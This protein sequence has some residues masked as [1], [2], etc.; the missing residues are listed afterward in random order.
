MSDHGCWAGG[1][2]KVFGVVAGCGVS[3]R[4]WVLK[5]RSSATGT[6]P[7]WVVVVV[8][9]V[10]SGLAGCSPAALNDLGLGSGLVWVVVVL[11]VV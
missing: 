3:A 11:C 5:K 6:A 9:V 7:S 2:G 8:G 4:C 1:C 10:F